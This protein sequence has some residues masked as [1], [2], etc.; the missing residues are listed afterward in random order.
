MEIENEI[1][2]ETTRCKKDFNCL[3]NEGTNCCK[4]MNCVNDKVHFVNYTSKDYCGY[5]M[6][7]GYSDICTCPIRKEIFSKYAL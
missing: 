1:Q 7:F 4:V 5:K 2:R 6:T 3:K